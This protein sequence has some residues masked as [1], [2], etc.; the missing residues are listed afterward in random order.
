[1]HDAHRRAA[2]NHELAAQAHRTAAEHS[3]K[4]D[5]DGGRWHA[6]RAQ[7]FAEQAYKLA[8]DAHAESGQI[9]SF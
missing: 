7:E 5:N 6:Q 3:E 4:G 9:V 8:Q 2:E 1:M